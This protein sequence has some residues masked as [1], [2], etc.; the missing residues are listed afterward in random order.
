MLDVDGEVEEM[1]QLYMSKGV[2]EE[3]A[4]KIMAILSKHRKPFVDIM[5]II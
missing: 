3:N 2:P 4:R 1:V 5:V